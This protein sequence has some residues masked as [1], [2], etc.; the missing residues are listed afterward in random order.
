MLLVAAV[1]LS[2]DLLF[3]FMGEVADLEG[4]YG[5]WEAAMFVLTTLPRRIYDYLPLVAFMG[6]LIGLGAMAKNSELVIIRASGV[7]TRRI[8]FFAMKPA[9]IVVL[10]GLFLGEFVA[11]VTEKIAQNKRAVAQGAEQKALHHKG[12][13]HREGDTFMHF[14]AVQSNGVLHGVSLQ[15]FDES[16]NLKGSIF[17]KRAIFQ[18]DHWV[19][20]S[21]VETTFSDGRS[22]VQRY[23]SKIW[24]TELSPAVLNV[25][26]VSP[27]DLSISGLYTYSE[28][29]DEQELNSDAY[30]M[31]FWKKS[32]QP[33]STGVLV[34]V[35]ISF[36][37]GPLRS[38]TMGFRVFTGVIVGLVFKFAQDLLGPSTIVFGLNPIYATLIP[39]SVCLLVGLLLLSRAR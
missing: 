8:V 20:E 15:Q 28:Y 21:V 5:F 31:S 36:V 18:R 35:A 24:D 10:I 6:A 39:I 1:V 7:S 29:L 38:V 4:Q 32:F 2:L 17:A 23:N 34:L 3:A 9:M 13:W 16:R 25:L 11:P 27:D 37:F 22:F 14:N 26:V 30:M 19:L 33:I 12:V